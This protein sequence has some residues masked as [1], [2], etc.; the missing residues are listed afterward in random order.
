MILPNN[1]QFFSP[2]LYKQITCMYHILSGNPFSTCFCSSLIQ[3]MKIIQL[4][5][6]SYF[7]ERAF[8]YFSCLELHDFTPF[9]KQILR[10]DPT[11]TPFTISKL[12]GH[13]CVFAKRGTCNCTKDIALPKMNLYVIYVWNVDLNHTGLSRREGKEPQQ[14]FVFSLVF[15][16]S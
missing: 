5:T 13:L 6:I 7:Y 15:S 16:L 8:S 9:N 14:P 1:C 12:P 10:E 4:S 3:I 11:V 2:V